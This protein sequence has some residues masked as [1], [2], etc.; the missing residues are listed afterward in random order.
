MSG[1]GDWGDSYGGT[2]ESADCYG[3]PLLKTRTTRTCTHQKAR[4]RRNAHG[5]MR[6]C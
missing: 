3:I 5:P 2:N 6:N 4:G 1:S